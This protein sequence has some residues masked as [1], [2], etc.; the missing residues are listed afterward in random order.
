MKKRGVLFFLLILIIVIFINGC[1]GSYPGEE[2]LKD[3]N[4]V[5]IPANPEIA[6]TPG[7]VKESA[8]N[9]ENAKDVTGVKEDVKKDEIK[10]GDEVKQ[11]AE[12]KEAMNFKIFQ[13][14]LTYPGAYN[15]PLYGT[16]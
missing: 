4:V 7:V 10:I 14:K 1:A 12:E 16:S 8:D 2:Q 6:E 11:T 5:D 3:D 9:V 15:G 13:P